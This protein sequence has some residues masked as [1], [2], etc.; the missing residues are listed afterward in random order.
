MEITPV[1]K[2]IKKGSAQFSRLLASN[3]TP[4]DFSFQILLP[5]TGDCEIDT[6]A[7]V[8]ALWARLFGTVKGRGMLRDALCAYIR[9][10]GARTLYGSDVSF[11]KYASVSNYDDL[12]YRGNGGEGFFTYWEPPRKE[13]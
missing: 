2:R 10:E 3:V 4:F 7:L 9:K 5:E 8:H 1:S 11:G 6:P 12:L 13:R